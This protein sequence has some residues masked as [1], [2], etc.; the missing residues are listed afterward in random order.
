MRCIWSNGWQ[1][2]LFFVKCRILQHIWRLFKKEI[3]EILD[4]T[5]IFSAYNTEK[6]GSHIQYFCNVYK[7]MN[8]NMCAQSGSAA[9]LTHL[10]VLASL[11]A[12][13]SNEQTAGSFVCSA[14][15]F[16]GVASEPILSLLRWLAVLL[17]LCHQSFVKGPFLRFKS[18]LQ[19]H[20]SDPAAQ[21]AKVLISNYFQ[22]RF[23][24][25][26]IL[27]VMTSRTAQYHSI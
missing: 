24:L 5:W 9:C 11:Q 3:F 26:I 25:A 8:G 27:S 13:V 4:A 23:N 2:L 17:L 18:W 15:L 12:L 6:I 19:Q 16:P 14:Q 22:Y 21:L 10:P 20:G 7:P 1:I